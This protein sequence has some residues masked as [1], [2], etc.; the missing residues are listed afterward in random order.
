[1]NI[2][3]TDATFRASASEWPG[4]T[5]GQILRDVLTQ[6][7]GLTVAGLIVGLAGA[8]MGTQL[9][10]SLLYG[11]QSSDAVTFTVVSLVLCAVALLAGYVP[12]RRATR[13]DPM[14]ALR[15]E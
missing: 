1:M 11:V 12:A 14:V 9:L 13:V 3:G 4:A 8:L 6:G 7:M 15:Y 5:R 2:S 10:T